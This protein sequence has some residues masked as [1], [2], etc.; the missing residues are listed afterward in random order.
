MQA[1]LWRHLV[2]FSDLQAVIYDRNFQVPPKRV[3]PVAPS[4]APAAT[5]SAAT[6]SS[7]AE[8]NKAPSA[9]STTT[10]TTPAKPKFSKQQIV[11]RLR[12]L[13]L[14]YEE[15]LLTDEFYVARV[16]ECDASQ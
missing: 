15:G 7:T 1:F 10:S 4:P 11:G 2:P 6:G 16:A 13:K 12:Q 9:A 3:P 8:A 5:T 14:L